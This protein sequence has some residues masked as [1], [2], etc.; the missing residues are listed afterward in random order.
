MYNTSSPFYF[1]KKIEGLNTSFFVLAFCQL[2]SFASTL[3]RFKTE[4]YW[5]KELW[6]IP[7]PL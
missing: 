7:F 6:P 5:E 4:V 1:E 2:S 3:V